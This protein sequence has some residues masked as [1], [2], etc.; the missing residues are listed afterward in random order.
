MTATPHNTTNAS[1]TAGI[2]FLLKTAFI[3]AVIALVLFSLM[4]GIRTEAG[5]DGQLTYWTRFGDLA[6][7]VAAVFG[8][9]IVI[10]LLRQWIGPTGAEKLVPASVQ[11]GVS[12][13]GRYLAPALLI[14]RA[15]G[16]RHLL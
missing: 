6:W 9:S 16:A 2:P 15:A 4:V 1:R 14:F 5:S 11:S 3:N 12:F 7:I 8:G 10:E 13:I